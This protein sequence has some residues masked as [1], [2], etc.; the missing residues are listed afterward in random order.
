MKNYFLLQ[1]KLLNRSIIAFGIPLILGYILVPLGFI[2]LSFFLFNRTEYAGYIFI[3]LGLGLIS[4]LSESARNDFLKSIFY[5]KDYLL[6][7]LIENTLYGSPFL[8]TLLI[9][10]RYIDALIFLILSSLMALVNV[11]Y[12]SNVVIPT[13]FGKKPFEYSIGFRKTFFL[14]P[15]AFVITA[16]SI[17]FENFNL[18]IFSLIL[19]GL[20]CLTYY[21]KP[22]N[23]YI[24]WNYNSTA[25]TFLLKK[26][27]SCLINF[28]LLSLPI[29]ASLCYYFQS[30]IYI[31]LIF[32]GLIYAYLITIVLAKYAAYP[33]EINLPQGLFIG[34]SLFY[35]PVLLLLIPFFISKS[36]KKLTPILNDSN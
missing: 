26:I 14:F 8:L 24:V 30:Q 10:S 19:S 29:T 16:I 25:K 28:T 1:L 18:G 9:N 35:P 2:A 20:I 11:N 31:I 12:S 32:A 17:Q 6:L 3:F 34:F 33:D 15:V 27:I 21:L 36:L 4:K 23:S 22:E 13:P 7:R 5:R